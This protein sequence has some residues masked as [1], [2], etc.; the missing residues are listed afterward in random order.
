MIWTI[1]VPIVACILISYLTTSML[2]KIVFLGLGL[3]ITITVGLNYINNLLKDSIS[4]SKEINSTKGG[5]NKNKKQNKTFQSTPKTINNKDYEE[6]V[7]AL[8]FCM[9]HK[10]L[11]RKQ[12][13]NFKSEVNNHLGDSKKH[14]TFKFEN[15]LHEIYCK[16]K[17]KSLKSKD[18]QELLQVLESY[19][20]N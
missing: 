6:L 1:L 4:K 5:S 17:N 13:L 18:Y 12:I 19:K 2:Y 20:T 10:L 14:Y 3:F 15:D 8:K 11:N 9:K 7:I 16:I